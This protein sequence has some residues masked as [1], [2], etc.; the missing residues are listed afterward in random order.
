MEGAA[1][2]GCG[3][4]FNLTRMGRLGLISPVGF[5][6]IVIRT[7]GLRNRMAWTTRII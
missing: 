6:K 2:G 3:R 1:D 4:I 5:L 7:G